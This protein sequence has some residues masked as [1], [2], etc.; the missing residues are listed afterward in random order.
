M[1]ALKAMVLGRG[2]I[3]LVNQLELI[4]A[5]QKTNNNLVVWFQ[6]AQLNKS[7]NLFKKII[8]PTVLQEGSL[9]TNT[10]CHG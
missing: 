2:S 7:L 3:C 8:F 1:A 5:N 6:S 9:S 4:V 10:S